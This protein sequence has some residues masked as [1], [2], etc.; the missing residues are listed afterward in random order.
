MTQQLTASNVNGGFSLVGALCFPARAS[1]TVQ[2][3]ATAAPTSTSNQL[4]LFYDDQAGSFDS[5]G[6]TTSGV[7]SCSELVNLARPVCKSNGQDC[8]PGWVLRPGVDESFTITINEEIKRQW[9][10]V[11]ANCD[12]KSGVGSPVTLTALSI[13]STQGIP[14]SSMSPQ[15]PDAGAALAITFLVMLLIV[16]ASTT[17]MF[18]K[19]SQ[20][21]GGEGGRGGGGGRTASG[22]LAAVRGSPYGGTNDVSAASVGHDEL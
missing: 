17:V 18:Y 7:G 8:S 22:L 11:L 16:F 13:T 21:S 5:F 4:L 19:K 10:F 6:T 15:G 1:D 3:K 14:C 9:Y 2:I 20:E 12:A